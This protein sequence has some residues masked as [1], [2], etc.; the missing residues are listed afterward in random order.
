MNVSDYIK[1]LQSFEEYAFSWDEILKYCNSPE[2]TLRK[3]L[4][5]LVE[6][7]E[8]L[9][10]RQGFY[11]IIPPR[12]QN[13]KKIPVE[14]YVDKL[15]KHLEKKYYI[16]LY[17]AA[18]IHGASHQRIQQD[19]VITVPPTVRDVEKGN[20]KIRFFKT[21]YWPKQNIIEKKSDAGLYKVSSPALTAADLVHQHHK[22]G[23]I[24][25]M[26]AN[27]EELAYEIN[28]EDLDQ[29]LS[30]YPYKSTLQRLGYLMEELD[31]EENILKYIYNRLRKDSFYPVILTPKKGMKA[32]STGNRWKVDVNVKLES[33]L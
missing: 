9:N 26:I 2:S 16:G 31:V 5:R 10:L 1:Q 25:R 12:Y 27:L 28:V 3:E 33:D 21:E 29:L 6:R 17:S 14:L 22:I 18:A 24:N 32:G 4:I 19:Y 13:L 7:N 11:L 8:I 30:W 20:T 23:G 15:F